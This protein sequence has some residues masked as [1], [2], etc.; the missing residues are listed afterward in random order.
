MHSRKTR[1]IFECGYIVA[2]RYRII[3]LIG[4]GG[5]GDIYSVDEIT[6]DEFNNKFTNES[7]SNPKILY[8][9]KIESLTAEKK[10]LDPEMEILSEI[11]DS[12]FFP[13]IHERGMTQ[14]HRFLVMELFGPSLSNT[15]R[16]MPSH[17]F[18]LGTVLRLGVYMI[19]CIKSFHEHG[20][21]HRDIKPGNFLLRSSQHLTT[22]EEAKLFK[23]DQSDN[24][25]DVDKEKKQNDN[26][27]NK[28]NIEANQDNDNNN[29]NSHSDSA[30]S[31]TNNNTTFTDSINNNNNS[32]DNIK[33]NKNLNDNK[34]SNIDDSQNNLSDINNANKSNQS[35]QLDICTNPIAL[36]DFGLSKRYIDPETSLPYPEKNRAGFRGT[37]KYA[38]IYAH[39]FNDQCP[40]DD[41]ISWCYS[42]VELIEGYLP[43]GN[44]RENARVRLIKSQIVPRNLFRSL[45]REFIDIWKYLNSLKY[46]VVCPKYDYIIQLIVEPFYTYVFNKNN[47]FLNS[48]L[49]TNSDL[50]DNSNLND[51]LSPESN[52]AF[53]EKNIYIPFDWEN[54]TRE[55]IESYSGVSYL[56]S[57]KN[58][59]LPKRVGGGLISDDDDVKQFGK[60]SR[61]IGCTVF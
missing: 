4:Q 24:I 26:E 9:M 21:V 14:T 17:K 31:N 18:S 60:S 51:T 32:I 56:P 41:L 59:P 16:Q 53:C 22:T 39:N 58:V 20:F 8:A 36:I 54:L 37:C 3:K 34:S 19:E 11:Q 2:G 52:S 12:P 10:G 13:H 30:N 38:S 46:D 35:F 23:Q 1:Q 7:S 44:I 61:C 49:N 6:N 28:N 43:W 42:M 5:Y 15:R 27:M 50:N 33:N 48:N 40:R 47:R 55:Q 29:S 25:N 45:P 57:A